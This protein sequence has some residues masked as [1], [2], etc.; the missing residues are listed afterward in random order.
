M[1]RCGETVAKLVPGCRDQ[2]FLALGNFGFLLATTAAATTALLRLGVFF[3]EGLR[4]Q[5]VHIGLSRGFRIFHRGVETNHVT[6]NHVELFEREHGF[7]L[8]LFA[9]TAKRKR[10]LFSAVHGVVQLQI[11]KPVI[12]SCF[13]FKR[14]FFDRANLHVAPR[15]LDPDHWI[16]ILPGF[17][18]IVVGKTDRLSFIHRRNVIQP[19]LNDRDTRFQPVAFLGL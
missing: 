14:N 16:S 8:D 17:N 10:L 19:I 5:K 6:R 18:K 1:N 13:N 12:I 2:L 11:A 4:F 7:T 3:L 9:P 15:P